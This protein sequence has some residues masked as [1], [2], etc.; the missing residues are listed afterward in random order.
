MTF[1]E[2]TARDIQY[3]VTELE[4]GYSK[5]HRD[6]DDAG[7][8]TRAGISSRYY[9][10]ID[11]ENMSNEQINQFY[12]TEFY[13]HFDKV[14]Y[15]SLRVFFFFTYVNLGISFKKDIQKHIN[16]MLNIFQK[17]MTIKVDG[18]I[19]RNT[20]AHMNIVME[21]IK[22]RESY[23]NHERVYLFSFID[24]CIREWKESGSAWKHLPGWMNR[25]YKQMAYVLKWRHTDV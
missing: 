3:L 8:I 21:C 18:L 20:V 17:H 24:Y 19:G 11:L 16:E 15:Y 22:K 2:E 1:S 23:G 6:P 14:P 10:D 9:P 13:S 5:I 25:L 7:G 12:H 4:G